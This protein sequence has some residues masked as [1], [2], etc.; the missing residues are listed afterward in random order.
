MAPSSSWC[1]SY[2]DICHW[3][4]LDNPRL[5]LYLEILNLITS[6]KTHFP[7]KVIVRGFRHED[8]DASLGWHFLAY[9]VVEGARCSN[10]SF[11]LEG[12]AW[13]ALAH[14][15]LDSFINMVEP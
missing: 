6:A 8:M 14:W 15:L 5:R 12:L 4:C 11:I 1:V 7:N 10:S 13:H 2:R 9:C 3:A